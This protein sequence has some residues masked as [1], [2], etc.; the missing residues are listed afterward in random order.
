MLPQKQNPQMAGC[1][2]RCVISGG[3][4]SQV[5]VVRGGRAEREAA[6]AV[7]HTGGRILH[8]N[9]W[10]ETQTHT[11]THTHRNSQMR[12]YLSMSLNNPR[13]LPP[14][15]PLTWCRTS[16]QLPIQVVERVSAPPCCNTLLLK[17]IINSLRGWNIHQ[18]TSS[19]ACADSGNQMLRQPSKL[20]PCNW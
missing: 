9:R 10:M 2:V 12:S 11:Q 14:S 1:E 15:H 19:T 13:R 17:H 4:C 6:G 18:L 7:T 5:L 3:D 8:S 20:Q 16:T